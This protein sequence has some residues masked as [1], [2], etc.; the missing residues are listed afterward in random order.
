MTKSAKFIKFLN[1][2]QTPENVKLLESVKQGFRAV[3]ENIIDGDEPGDY[4]YTEQ[5]TTEVDSDQMINDDDMR[6]DAESEQEPDVREVYS[7]VLSLLRDKSRKMSDDKVSELNELL[8]EFFNN[9]F[10][11]G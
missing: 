3:V 2:L 1:T 11:L 5:D 4:D 10:K 7:E 8:K 6:Q 9:P